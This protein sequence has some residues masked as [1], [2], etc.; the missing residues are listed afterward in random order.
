MG[1]DDLRQSIGLTTRQI[2]VLRSALYFSNRDLWFG[3]ANRLY[4]DSCAD[5]KKFLRRKL[6]NRDTEFLCCITLDGAQRVISYDELYK[7]GRDDVT[8]YYPEIIKLCMKKNAEFVIVAHNH[9]DL[10]RKPSKGDIQTALE[11]KKTLSMFDIIMLDDLV[12]AGNDIT[13]IHEIMT[14]RDLFA[15]GNKE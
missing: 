7:G 5:V 8:F 2:D 12:I 4:V 13:S 14:Y 3:I 9:P 6:Q 15:V 10:V 11:L 1:D